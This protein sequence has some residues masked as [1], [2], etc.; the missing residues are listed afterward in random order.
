MDVGLEVEQE[1]L[2]LLELPVRVR[3]VRVPIIAATEPTTSALE[4][5]IVNFL[6]YILNS[7]KNCPQD[8]GRCLTLSVRYMKPVVPQ[9]FGTDHSFFGS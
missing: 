1:R 2:D 5:R 3:V 7:A 8:T 6:G 9:S 4:S